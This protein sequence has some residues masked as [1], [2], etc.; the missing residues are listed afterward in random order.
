MSVSSLALSVA[1]PLDL[2][3]P[4][5]NAVGPAAEV[6]LPAGSLWRPDGHTCWR[7]IVCL[8]GR[9]WITQERDPRDYVLTAGEFFVVNQPGSVLVQAM[10]D[11]RIQVTPS[12]RTAPYVG[13]WRV[14]S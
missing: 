2:G 9:V 11:A 4:L 1:Q 10:V 8:Q 12:L 6:V 14:F 7:V 3:V 5:R 13:Q